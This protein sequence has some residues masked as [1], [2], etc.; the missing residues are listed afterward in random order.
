[1]TTRGATGNIV[2]R[3]GRALCADLQQRFGVLL[4]DAAV[5]ASAISTA[6][7]GGDADLRVIPAVVSANQ[8]KAMTL[9]T[10]VFSVRVDLT[11]R[12]KYAGR[13][14]YGCESDESDV[15]EPVNHQLFNTIQAI[16]QPIHRHLVFLPADR[17]RFAP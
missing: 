3:H 4:S 6:C 9:K 12:Q 11:T 10:G 7:W 13:A 2:W 1:M 17:Q 15:F 8:Q 16:L 14:T 5:A